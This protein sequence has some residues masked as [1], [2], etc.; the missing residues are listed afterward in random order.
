M[1]VA[2]LTD[3]LACFPPRDELA[4]EVLN[5]ISQ[6]LVDTT[7]DIALSSDTRHLGLVIAVETQKFESGN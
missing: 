5:T 6:A 4:V 2:E 3:Y 1:T 7:Y